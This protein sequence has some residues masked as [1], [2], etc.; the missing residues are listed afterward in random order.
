M[1]PDYF[2]INKSLM[3]FVINSHINNDIYGSDHCPIELL[4]DFVALH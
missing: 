4:I 1:R 3:P 2:L